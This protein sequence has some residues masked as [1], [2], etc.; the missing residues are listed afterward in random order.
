MRGKQ[1]DTN[2]G[3]GNDSERDRSGEDCR[4]DK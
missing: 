2:K 1:T 3:G 4:K